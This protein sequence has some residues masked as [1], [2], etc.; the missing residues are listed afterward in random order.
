MTTPQPLTPQQRHILVYLRAYLGINQQLPPCNH[1]ARD[2]GYAS[3]NAA[4]DH[5][6]RL[7]AK[8]YLDKNEANNWRLTPLGLAE[9]E[10]T[11]TEP[12]PC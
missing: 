12:T 6:Q 8:G 11:K 9:T 10:P 5:L 4:A 7:A 2:F 3:P 1:I